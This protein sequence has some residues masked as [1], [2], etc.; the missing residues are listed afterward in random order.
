MNRFNKASDIYHFTILFAPEVLQS[1]R[2]T[3]IHRSGKNRKKKYGG[4]HALFIHHN[5]MR[6]SLCFTF[7]ISWS[8][9]LL[10]KNPPEVGDG[11]HS[12]RHHPLDKHKGVL[13]CF[14]VIGEQ[15][16]PLHTDKRRQW[17]RWRKPSCRDCGATHDGAIVRVTHV[18]PQASED[19]IETKLAQ[20]WKIHILIDKLNCGLYHKLNKPRQFPLWLF[21]CT[22]SQPPSSFLRMI[23]TN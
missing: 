10:W 8:V 2:R 3:L 9:G 19:P 21:Y 14:Q 17:S 16:C 18:A 1:S 11:G 15:A 13:F 4:H 22:S 20:K 12:H 6:L 5:N 23:T 7:Q